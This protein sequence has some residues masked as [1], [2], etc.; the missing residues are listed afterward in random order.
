[1]P[2][3]DPKADA[4]SAPRFLYVSGPPWMLDFLIPVVLG[5]A[6]LGVG[7]VILLEVLSSSPP[8]FNVAL[9]V[10]LLLFDY[11]SLWRI[12]YRVE[13]AN[14]LLSC[15][16]LFSSW[17]FPIAQVVRLRPAAVDIGFEVVETRSHPRRVLV[18]ISKGFGP[19]AKALEREHPGIEVRIGW[20][21][22]WLERMPWPSSFRQL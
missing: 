7:A 21:S 8:W 1:M 11:W 5:L 14:G 12:A 13:Y 10:F 2:I 19:F 20:A 22:R 9:L 15:R 4:A 17:N 16:G 6:T 3:D 18:C